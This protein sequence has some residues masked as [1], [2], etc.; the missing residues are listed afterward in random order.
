MQ[1]SFSSPD[2]TESEIDSVSAVLRSGWITTGAVGAEFSAG[3]SALLG[4]VHVQ[5][6]SSCTAGMELVMELLNVGPGDEVIAPAYTFTATV[7]PALRRGAQVRFVDLAEDQFVPDVDR[8]MGEVSN[9]TKAIIGVDFG[10][11]VW[12]YSELRERL[13]KMFASSPVGSRPILVADAAHSLGATSGGKSSALLADVAV[14]SFHAVKNLTTAEGGCIA[15]GEGFENRFD[16]AKR[17]KLLS[18]HGQDRDARDKMAAGNWKYDIKEL[19]TKSNLPD[20]LAAVGLAQ[21]RRYPS[22]LSRRRSI[23]E[24][25]SQLADDIGAEFISHDAPGQQ[26]S[27][28]LA[29]MKLP[30]GISISRDEVMSRLASLGIAANVHYQPLP[31][32]SAYQDAGY[33]MAG[34]PNSLD[35]YR[36]TL[37]L[38]LSSALTD[39]ETDY[40]ATAMRKLLKGA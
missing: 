36:R 34:L 24:T 22:M 29:T 18:L 2:I 9:R 27:Y 13:D 35:T 21:L 11:I 37:S 14:Y 28:H 19:G 32:L 1:V 39:Q 26:S 8:V 4:G 17:F 20:I 16:A 40:V 31:L 33:S 38:P 30:G 15:W 7:A 23:C 10:G 5:L 25:Y 6:M 12:R 3:L